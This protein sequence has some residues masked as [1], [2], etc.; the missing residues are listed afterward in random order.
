MISIRLRVIREKNRLYTA[1][2]NILS[3]IQG[4]GAKVYL[5]HDILEN[6]YD[7]KSKFALSARSFETFLSNQLDQGKIP[8]SFERLKNG[9]LTMNLP[10]NGFIISFDDANESVLHRAYP[11]LKKLN[12][13]FII[14][15]NIEL[16]DKP[17]FLSEDQIKVLL[18]DPLCTLG[19]HGCRHKVFR[20]LAV[21]DVE[22]ELSESKLLL[23]KKFGVNVDF[24]AF[25]Y[26]RLVECSFRNIQQLKKSEYLFSFSAISGSLNQSWLS[27]KFFL[28]RINVDENMAENL[29]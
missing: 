23:E 11:I 8:L 24:F 5:F 22:Q 12:I 13:P 3:R 25:P 4:E 19:S 1:L 21:E 20:Y 26:G 14:F 16:I 15:I 17:N 28:P 7:V 2:L 9:I 29:N 27:S 10:S 6:K 18:L